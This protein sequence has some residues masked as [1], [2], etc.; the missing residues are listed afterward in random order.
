M[1]LAE[2]TILDPLF[3][4]VLTASETGCWWLSSSW[5]ILCGDGGRWETEALSNSLFPNG[6]WTRRGAF[7]GYL[8]K[9]C[10][11][12][13]P[14]VQKLFLIQ[15]SFLLSKLTWRKCQTGATECL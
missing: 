12:W 4:V 5:W 1:Q 14:P 7:R 8:V 10:R 15:F 13:N 6:R 9:Y 3:G 2:V 11:A